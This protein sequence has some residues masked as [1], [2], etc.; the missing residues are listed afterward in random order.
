MNLLFAND[1]RGEYPPSLYAEQNPALP[2]FPRLRGEMHRALEQI[3][4]PRAGAPRKTPSA[5][6]CA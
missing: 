6:V 3:V 2:P 4:P 5:S 1:R